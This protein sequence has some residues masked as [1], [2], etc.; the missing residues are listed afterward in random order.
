[1]DK[2]LWVMIVTAL[3]GIL[4][5]LLPVGFPLTEPQFVEVIIYIVLAVF[6]GGATRQKVLQIKGRLRP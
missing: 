1:M 3:A 4:Y 6:F 2:N 5:T